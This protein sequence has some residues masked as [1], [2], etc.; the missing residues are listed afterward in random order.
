MANSHPETYQ[1]SIPKA[2]EL[3]DPTKLTERE[4]EA[5]G[6]VYGLTGYRPVPLKRAAEVMGLSGARVRELRNSAQHRLEGRKSVRK[7]D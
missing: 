4:A 5:F 2:R 3:W 1:W 7:T 6:L